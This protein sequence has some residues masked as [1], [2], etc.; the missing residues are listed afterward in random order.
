[1]LALF[2]AAALTKEHTVVLP[3]LLLLT[4]YFWNPPFSFQG[5]R[6]NWRLYAPVVISAAALGMF[7]LRKLRGAETAGFAIKD[8]TWYQ[9]FIT[10]CRAFWVYIRLF[11]FPAGLDI[12][13]DFPISHS[14]LE[15]G[16]IFG[17]VAIVAAVAAAFYYRRQYP[18]AAYGFFTFLILMAPTSSFIPIKD[19]VAERRLYLS[20]IG[21]LLITL[22]CLRRVDVRQPKWMAAMAAVLLLAAIATNRRNV[23]WT[24]AVVLWEDTVAKSPGNARAH[25]QLA[26]AYYDRGDYAKALPQYEK[27]AQLQKPDD[28]LFIDWGLAYDQLNQPDQALTKLK[29]AAAMNPTAHVYS[30]IGMVYGKQGRNAEAL[31]ALARAEQFNPNFEMTYV[32]RGGVRQNM[33]DLQGAIKDFRQGLAI[34]P[35]NQR[36]AQA[37]VN[38]E[39]ILRSRP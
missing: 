2:A 14:L 39:A 30:Q 31:E 27:V 3:A 16:A 6:R 19:P 5:I 8:L 29:Q 18:L 38:A 13:Y 26:Q 4:D 22:E 34:N 15:H 7:L 12:D 10:E 33:G 11:L 24:D 9:Y 35:N 20:M 28:R 1:M 37:L 32:Y 17:L 21:L 25:F 23:V 36:A